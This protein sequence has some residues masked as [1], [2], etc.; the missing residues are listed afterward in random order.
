LAVVAARVALNPV[1][2]RQHNRH[3]VF[4]PTVMLAAWLFGLG[5]GLLATAAST[6]TLALFWTPGAS[7]PLASAELVLFLVIS[8]A[9]CAL[10]ES[11]DRARRRADAAVSARDQLLAVVA[12]D[13]RNPLST[14]RLSTVVL[15]RATKD[16][17]D[18]DRNLAKVERAVAHMDRLIGDLVGIAQI[19][20]GRLQVVL[21][22]EPVDSIVREAAEAFSLRAQERGVALRTG[23]APPEGV[24]LGD[25]GRLVQVLGNLL[26]NALR[27]TSRGDTIWLRAEGR[28]AEVL[29]EVEDTGPGI[30]PENV[31]HVFDRNWK[32]AG[33]GSGLGL[34][35][36]RSI[37]NAHGGRLEVRTQ[38]G[39]GATFF[40]T[41]P[42]VRASSQGAAQ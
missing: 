38:P 11:L 3:L 14:V 35:I 31:P 6:V 37:V 24:L 23:D 21:R 36:A 19:D 26:D 8:G 15:R 18:R 9:V 32:T 42:R 25:R 7:S 34:F 33:G 39:H 1:W 17:E 30:P 41:V 22:P 29:F 5:P 2:G 27:V 20:Q 40:F 4:L 16:S 10:I 13:L 28:D 12:H